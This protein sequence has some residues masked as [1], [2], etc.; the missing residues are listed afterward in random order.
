MN[1]SLSKN[2]R[3]F[4]KDASLTQ[5]QLAQA[6]GVTV[7]AVSKWESGSSIPDLS[8][9]IDLASYF[10]TSID[11]LLGYSLKSR[12]LN[13]QL[14]HIRQ[15]TREKKFAEA[16]PETERA[17]LH[18]P[19]DFQI[20]YY[21]AR[22]FFIHG[23]EE[24]SEPSLRRSLELYQRAESL[25]SQNDNPEI[26]RTG[27]HIGMAQVHQLLGNREQSL[28]LLK[29]NNPEGINDSM[30]GLQLLSDPDQL[31]ES[32]KYL[33]RAL[34]NSLTHLI[35]ITSL[36]TIYARQNRFSE[37]LYLLE[38]M[39]NLLSGLK[40]PVSVC[41]IDRY[42]AILLAGSAVLHAEERDQK[43]A[44]EMLRQA[45]AKA[46]VFDASPDYSFQHC[47]FLEKQE[48]AVAYDEFGGSTFDA[49]EALIASQDSD[50]AEW[51]LE[52]WKEIRDE[53]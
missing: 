18:F 29:R 43:K 19:N 7:G 12:P 8:L 30:I 15:L 46:R 41:V 23:M 1:H 39:R 35:R 50:L 44:R 33:T 9:I 52:A 36:S 47:Y 6:M 24:N 11:V 31:E 49:I 40:R 16:I 37:A 28:E 17:L 13:Q 45:A 53:Q 51:L 32:Q 25:L 48:S 42:E 2:I 27:I 20:Q 10:S 26:S 21:S 22:L 14:E 38:W 3:I 34:M 4:R 5:E